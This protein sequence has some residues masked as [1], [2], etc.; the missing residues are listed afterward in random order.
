MG[1]R[2]YWED[3]AHTIVRYDFEGKW[4]WEE[5]YPVYNLAIAMETSAPYRVDII[6]DMRRSQG[7]PGNA[8]SHLKNISDKQPANVGLSIFVTESKFLLALYNVGC[9]FYY[10]IPQYFQ[11]VSTIEAAREMIASARQEKSV[12]AS[13]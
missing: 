5:L 10:K 13:P 7:V 8:L 4:T 12:P 1:V 3:E 2:V 11:V 9:K 6:L